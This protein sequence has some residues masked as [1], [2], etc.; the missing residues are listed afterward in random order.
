MIKKVTTFYLEMTDKLD[1][2]PKPGYDKLIELKQVS[3]DVFQQWMLFVGVG[4]PWRWYSRLKW[5]P[6]EWEAY[7]REN[8]ARTYLAFSNN[9]LVG[10]FELCFSG[11]A[12]VEIKF[13]GLFPSF[14]GAGYGGALLSHAVE[15]AWNS[16]AQKIWL[17]TCTSDHDAALKNY[18][19]RGFR[20]V[21]TTD[22][23]ETIPDKEEYLKL[24]SEFL[25]SYFDQHHVT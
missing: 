12:S 3:G 13:F 24:T 9:S 16:G 23:M 21:N 11:S 18:L 4:M 25:G 14:V 10:Y 19:S 5:T 17:H 6:G 22:E 1:F 20:M 2:K 8:D 7:F 15:V